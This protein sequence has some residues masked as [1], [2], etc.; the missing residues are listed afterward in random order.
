[1][2]T[3][4]RNLR[5]YLRYIRNQRRT[6]AEAAPVSDQMK[7]TFAGANQVFYDETVIKQ[8]DVPSFSG[9]FGI[10]PKHVPTLAVL[11]PGVVTVYE[12]DGGVKKIFVSSGTV[13]INEN[14]SVQ[15]LAEEA[16]P[17]E[18]LDGTAAKD[19]LSKAQQQLSAASSEKDRAEAN[20][21]IEVAEAL[22]QA[23]Q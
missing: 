18:N 19:L 22:V 1:M 10:L 6:F 9:S 23:L 15:V 12:E 4:A 20:I 14:N 3:L 17:L 16:H 8:V 7:F 5:P 2:A 21:A 11:K 13:T